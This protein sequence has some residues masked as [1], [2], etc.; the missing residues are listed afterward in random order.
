MDKPNCWKGMDTIMKDAKESSIDSTCWYV[1][2]WM[3]EDLENALLA[4]NVSPTKD[5]IRLLREECKHLFDDKSER[6]EM[7]RQ[8]AESLFEK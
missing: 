1:E 8:M 5:N 3:D 2:R 4:I 6:N 7:I